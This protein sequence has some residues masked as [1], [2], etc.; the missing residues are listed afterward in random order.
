MTDRWLAL[1]VAAT[2]LAVAAAA[3]ARAGDPARVPSRP[4]AVKAHTQQQPHYFRS[5]VS[6]ILNK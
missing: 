2:I 4:P 3:M 1:V 6:R 5:W